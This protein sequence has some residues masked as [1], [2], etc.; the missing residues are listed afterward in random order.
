MKTIFVIV[1]NIFAA[2][3]F[4][5]AACTKDK[6]AS[7]ESLFYGKWESNVGDTII[8]LQRE[9][10]NIFQYGTFNLPSVPREVGFSYENNKLALKNDMSNPEKLQMLN[11]F[12]W[13]HNRTTFE[14][15]GVDM[16][17]F[18]SSTS[19]WFSFTKIP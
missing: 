15:Q 16:Y 12:K 3:S 9:G 10:R 4:L 13:V 5:I 8:F 19:T 2:L 1:L 18:M 11:S 17:S 7:D 14:V 6:S